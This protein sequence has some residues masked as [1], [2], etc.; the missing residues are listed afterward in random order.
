MITLSAEQKALAGTEGREKQYLNTN[1]RDIYTEAQYREIL[2]QAKFTLTERQIKNFQKK[3]VPV[4]C[5]WTWVT[6][7]SRFYPHNEYLGQ[8]GMRWTYEDGTEI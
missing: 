1:N 4:I 2:E 5:I 8:Y 3:V 6:D 7:R